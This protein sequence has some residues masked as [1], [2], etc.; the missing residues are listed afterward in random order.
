MQFDEFELRLWS[1]L[2]ALFDAN[3]SIKLAGFVGVILK[4]LV[5]T[6]LILSGVVTDAHAIDIGKISGYEISLTEQ[7]YEKILK[8]DG[9][10]M[11]RNAIIHFYEV[12]TVAGVP[13]I[14]GSSSA[15]GNACDGS[16]FVISFPLNGKPRLDGPID[17]CASVSYEIDQGKVV[18]LSPNIPGKG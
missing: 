5:I 10:E 17:S 3:T 2:F 18:F 4:F 1:C 14:V 11:H 12:T 8:V 16:P 7:D 15:G 6:C 13:I 9:R